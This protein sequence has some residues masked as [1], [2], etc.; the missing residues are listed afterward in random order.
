[1]SLAVEQP[2]E[3]PKL[4]FVVVLLA[5]GRSTAPNSSA[6]TWTWPCATG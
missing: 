4:P 5:L 6:S 2:G 1:M 3:R